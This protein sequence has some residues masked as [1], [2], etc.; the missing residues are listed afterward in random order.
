MERAMSREDVE[1]EVG[2]VPGAA[3]QV[4]V[5]SLRTLLPAVWLNGEVIDAWFALLNARSID[6]GVF[7]FGVYFMTK[8]LEN[9]T[10]EYANV[11]RWYREVDIGSMREILIPVHVGRNHWTLVHVDVQRRMIAYHD[12]LGGGGGVF[13]AA[14]VRY[15]RDHATAKSGPCRQTAS[16]TIVPTDRAITPQQVGVGSSWVCSVCDAMM[17]CHAAMC[18]WHHPES[19]VLGTYVGKWYA[20]ILRACR[21]MATIVACLSAL[22]R[23]ASLGGMPCAMSS[24]RWAISVEE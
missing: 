1:A 24:L 6:A 3:V 19:C 21:T 22:L 20:S 17:R 10:Y 7:A 23:I 8:L 14:V 11:A 5:S 9:G 2:N 4:T 18:V 16:W 13:L 12:S 15:L